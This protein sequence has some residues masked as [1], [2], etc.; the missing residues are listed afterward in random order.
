LI[1]NTGAQG[2]GGAVFGCQ[3]GEMNVPMP[4]SVISLCCALAKRAHSRCNTEENERERGWRVTHGYCGCT[5][6]VPNQIRRRGAFNFK[7]FDIV[8]FLLFFVYI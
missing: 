1:T 2:R 3:P 7:I 8:I 6:S 5:L 4:T